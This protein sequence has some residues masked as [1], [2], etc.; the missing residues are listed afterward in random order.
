MGWK[1]GQSG[2]LNG[3]PKRQNSYDALL[4]AIAIVEKKQDKSILRHFIEQAFLDNKVLV[5]AMKKIM[6]DMQAV[7]VSADES[8]QTLTVVFRTPEPEPQ[9]MP[10]PEQQTRDDENG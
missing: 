8:L 4:E 10:D 6:P 1:K 2:N 7:S 5:A 9:N 3:R